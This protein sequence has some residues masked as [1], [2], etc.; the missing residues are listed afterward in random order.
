M[1]DARPKVYITRRIPQAAVD[2]LAAACDVRHWDHDEPVPRGELLANVADVDALYSLLTE[3]VDQELLDHA[4][5][6]RVVSQMAVGYDN[7]DIAA[8]TARGIPVGHTPE[9]LTETTADLTWALMMAAARRLVEAAEAVKD[10]QW[11]TWK[12]MWMTGPDVYGA[13]LGIFGL[14]R[15]GV[16]MARRAMGFNMRVLYHD[17]FESPHAAAVNARFVDLPT[18]LAESDFVTLHCPLTPETRGMVNEDFLRRMKPTAILVNTAR[19][20]VV[21]E[22]ALYRA[23][24]EGWIHAA[25]LDVTQVEPLPMDSPLLTLPNCLVLPHIGSASIPTRTRMATLAAEN[26]LAGLAGKP[27]VYAVNAA[28]L[29][30]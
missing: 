14:G 23:L 13:T 5:R 19:G 18:L 28:A 29:G 9:V 2:M 24:S 21:D 15:I 4:P 6:L 17:A 20:P 12:P 3:K 16:A 8:C 22:P 7:I 27:L 1:A 25:G 10:G 11:T 26:L 30:G